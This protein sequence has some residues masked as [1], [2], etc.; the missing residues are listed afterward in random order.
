MTPK[1]LP[2]SFAGVTLAST[3][4]I[5]RVPQCSTLSVVRFST[6]PGSSDMPDTSLM[7]RLAHA[8]AALTGLASEA[9]GSEDPTQAD[10]YTRVPQ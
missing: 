10:C 1:D 6:I 2:Q 9:S 7:L 8:K 5:V 4:H 3:G